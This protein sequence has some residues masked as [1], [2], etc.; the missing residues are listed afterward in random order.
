MKAIPRKLLVVRKV[1]PGEGYVVMMEVDDR[2]RT[3]QLSTAHGEEVMAKMQDILITFALQRG[4][5]TAEA[6]A[7]PSKPARRRRA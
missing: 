6:P 1:H 3:V 5:V 2:T 4:L 7:V